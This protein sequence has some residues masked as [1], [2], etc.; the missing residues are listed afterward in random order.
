MIN[1]KLSFKV[2]RLTLCDLTYSRWR[3]NWLPDYYMS[4]TSGSIKWLLKQVIFHKNLV[5]KE[6]R[7]CM[8]PKVTH[9]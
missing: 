7:T 9:I 8:I 3:P 4:D 2:I 1:V 6:I 5:G